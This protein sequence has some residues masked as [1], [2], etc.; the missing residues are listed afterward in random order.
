MSDRVFTGAAQSGGEKATTKSTLE[1]EPTGKVT[2]P[3]RDCSTIESIS[4]GFRQHMF[5]LTDDEGNGGSA[6][7]GAGWGTD[8]IEM[9]WKN[10][11]DE[12]TVV[13]RGS[14]LLAAWVETFDPAAA[15]DLRK[16]IA[17]FYP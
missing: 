4:L 17:R 11:K 2:V 1:K 10:G 15:K 6:S 8:V 14:E 7:T 3:I 16:A 13:V 12:R 9:S 5:D